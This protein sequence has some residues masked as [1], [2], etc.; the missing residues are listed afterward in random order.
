[1]NGNWVP[2]ISE[3][4][5]GEIQLETGYPEGY[6]LLEK[7][8]KYLQPAASNNDIYYR[9]EIA[10]GTWEFD[11]YKSDDSLPSSIYFISSEPKDIG[12]DRTKGYVFSV[13][14]GYGIILT[15]L[16]DGDHEYLG[17]SDSDYI[18]PEFWYR[19]KIERSTDGEISLY[20][21]GHSFSYSDWTLINFTTGDNPVIDNTYS[22]NNYFVLEL[23]NDIKFPTGDKIA[24]IKIT[25]QIKE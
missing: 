9:S 2:G 25:N 14:S 7:G 17:Y 13:T 19:F 20:I 16:D 1:M 11:F 4:Y 24:N 12:W 3:F 8:D 23:N 15:R 10:Y 18:I 5:V 21:K 22:D 6:P